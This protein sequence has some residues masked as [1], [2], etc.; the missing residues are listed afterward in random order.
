MTFEVETASGRRVVQLT[1]DQGRYEATVDGRRW[2]VDAARAGGGVWSLIVDRAGGGRA[3]RRSQAVT[4]VEA[5][6]GE[7]TVLVN[8]RAMPVR[9]PGPLAT[10]GWARR[11]RHGWRAALPA[12]T[13]IGPQQIVAPM[14]GR[15]VKVLVKPGDA[16]RAR[17][18]LVVVEAMKMENELRA[19]RAGIVREVRVAQG[20]PVEANAVLVILD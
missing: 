8:G 10:A 18:G 13:T 9:V 6:R 14:P 20:A 3:A 17:Q 7:L 5:A 12:D 19:S 2:A 16:V 11:A 1:G 4:V 15:V